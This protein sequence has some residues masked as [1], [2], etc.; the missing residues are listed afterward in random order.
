MPVS[1]RRSDKDERAAVLPPE[2]LP[3]FDDRFVTSCDLIEEYVARLALETFRV[4]GLGEA[5]LAECSAD[6]AAVR[7]GL[8]P[9]IARVPV[10][11]LLRT[12]ASRDWIEAVPGANVRYRLTR[13]LPSLDSSEI[14]TAQA[15]HDPQCLP[16]YRIAA[17]AA[18]HYP[19]ILRGETTGEDALFTPEHIGA[20]LEYF[21]NANPL[22]AVANVIGAIAVER[23]LPKGGA[24]LELGGGLGSGSEALL[25]RLEAVGRGADVSAYRFTDIVPAFLRRSKK[26]LLAR[27]PARPIAVGM[28][29]IDQPF[30]QAGIAAGGYAVVYGVNVLHVAR[31]LTATLAEIRQVLAEDGVLVACECVRPFPAMPLYVEFVFNLLQSFRDPLLVPDWRPNG[32]F[33]TP[34]QWVA[35][36]AANGFTDLAIYPDVVA[37]R[38][39]YPQFIAAAIVA[40]RG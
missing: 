10:A 40:R 29:D 7:A 15:A 33:L 39:A 32:G 4:L 16:S 37:I 21:S 5:C 34:E 30:A 28:L 11:W 18:Q 17:L 25:D 8:Q 14:A 35:A 6:E 3:R 20:W 9:A 26:T 1:S 36:L 38:D 13:P 31:D 22:Y 23:A 2:L 27:F 24:I 19:A 12:L